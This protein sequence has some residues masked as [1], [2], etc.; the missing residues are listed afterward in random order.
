MSST[1]IEGLTL[2]TGSNGKKGCTCNCVGCS[3]EKYG[4]EHPNYQGTIEQVKDI[5]KIA[6]NIK[7]TIILGNPDWSYVKI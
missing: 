2:Y 4:N 6:P 3:Q 5:L 7:R 1:T